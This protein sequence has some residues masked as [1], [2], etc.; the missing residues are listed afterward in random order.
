MKWIEKEIGYVED[1]FD[2]Y[3]DINIMDSIQM[4]KESYIDDMIDY[5][6]GDLVY[7]SSECELNEILDEIGHS[8]SEVEFGLGQFDISSLISTGEISDICRKRDIIWDKRKITSTP[9]N[10]LSCGLEVYELKDEDDSRVFKCLQC[11]E[12]RIAD[13]LTRFNGYTCPNCKRKFETSRSK[14][15]GEERVEFLLQELNIDYIREYSEFERYRFDFK[16]KHNNIDYYI[17]IHGMQHFKPVDFF[18]GIEVFNKLQKSDYIKKK[19]AENNG[20]YVMLDFREHNVEILEERF[21]NEFY[22]KYIKGD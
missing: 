9:V 7:R 10:T 12:F 18:G 3:D 8:N 11:G 1:F 14:S 5:N 22:Y 2:S 16:I 6:V 15:R 21:M 19:Y 20:V 13:A 17:E 4:I